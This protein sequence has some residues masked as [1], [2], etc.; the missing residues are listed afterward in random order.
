MK[1]SKTHNEP[2]LKDY[3]ELVN[4]H[5]RQSRSE[6]SDSPALRRMRLRRLKK[7]AAKQKPVE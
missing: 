4:A 6:R 2:E 5:R 7:L 1:K 3:R